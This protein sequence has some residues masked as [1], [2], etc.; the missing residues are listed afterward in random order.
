MR[1]S[2]TKDTLHDLTP[3]DL[4]GVVGGIPIPTWYSGCI[5]TVYP[6]MPECAPEQTR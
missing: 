4:A 1:L 5:T 3:E 2:L 6:T